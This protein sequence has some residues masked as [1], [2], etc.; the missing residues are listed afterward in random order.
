MIMVEVDSNY[1]DA[2][3]MK[4]RTG[5]EHIKAYQKLLRHITISEVCNQEMHILDNKVSNKFQD[6]IRKQCKMQMIPLDTHQQ[7]IAERA[8]QSFKNHY[9]V[10]LAG[11]DPRFPISL[12]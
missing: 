8:I 2:Q 10:I 9:L 11:V 5:K 4:N 7:N 6:K 12:W 1:I 3:L